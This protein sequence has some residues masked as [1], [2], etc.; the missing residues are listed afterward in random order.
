MF[1]SICLKCR[2][3]FSLERG[4]RRH[5]TCGAS[6]TYLQGDEDAII[7][8]GD[9]ELMRIPA[10]EISDCINGHYGVQLN[11]KL[12]FGRQVNTDFDIKRAPISE[13]KSAFSGQSK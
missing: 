3:T 10:Q 2:D 8:Y 1:L 9:A 11:V 12:E 5:C 6:A 13:T 7:L 4:I